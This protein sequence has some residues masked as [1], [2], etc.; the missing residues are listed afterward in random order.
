[1]TRA[2]HTLVSA[3]GSA[4]AS[5]SIESFAQ[6]SMRRCSLL[7][8]RSSSHPQVLKRISHELAEEQIPSTT[9][10]AASPVTTFAAPSTSLA[11]P[12][13]YSRQPSP[14]SRSQDLPTFEYWDGIVAEPPQ[15]DYSSF[16]ETLA[17]EDWASTAVSGSDGGGEST[18][19]LAATW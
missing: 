7:D 13:T 12:S 18:G 8:S 19:L 11:V 14:L 6:V 2:A 5:A 15:D 17:S 1:M 9:S 3:T 10:Y 16:F 4:P